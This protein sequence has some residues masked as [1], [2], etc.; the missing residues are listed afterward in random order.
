VRRWLKAR[1]AY[2]KSIESLEIDLKAA[3]AVILQKRLT[4]TVC[5][6]CYRRSEKDPDRHDE[7][8]PT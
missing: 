2:S 1:D 6:P 7:A 3:K 5:R 4:M 8:A